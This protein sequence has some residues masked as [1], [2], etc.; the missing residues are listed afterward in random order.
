M[1]LRLEQLHPSLVHLPIAL[2]PLAIGADLLGSITARKSFH[3]LGRRSIA[4]AAAG[5]VVSAISGLIAGEEVN[6]K[7]P[8]RDKLMT[9][10]NLNAVATLVATGAA[11]W[12]A[13]LE[14]PTAAYF[15]IGTIGMSVLAYTAYLGGQ[16]V[17]EAGAGVAPA[18]GVF[19][20]DAPT[21][22]INRVRGFAR[23]AANDLAH[24][25]QH[26]IKELRQGY[27]LPAIAGRRSDSQT[28][29]QQ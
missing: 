19:R 18:H 7:G 27:L 20:P 14:K 16:L 12:R 6:V 11:V 15:A 17:Y 22:R 24:G 8:S 9:H 13:R 28:T 21:L 10:R 3:A 26:M 29:P 2:L 1:T 23:A 4:L 5:A 25:V